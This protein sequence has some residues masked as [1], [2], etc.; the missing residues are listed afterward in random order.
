MRVRTFSW[1]MPRRGSLLVI[2]TSSAT[3]C[4]PSPTTLG[5]HPLGDG[6]DLV[7][8]DE[9]AVVVAG[10]EGLDDDARRE[11]LSAQRA[12]E[13]GADGL[14]G[15]EVELDA[16]AVVA[17]ERL[18][19]ARVAE[20]LRGGDR[21]RP[22]SSTTSARGTGSPASSSRRLVRLLSRRRRRRCRTSA[23][24][25]RPDPLLVGAVA[26][27]D[28]RVAVEADE[29]DVAAAASSMSAWVEGP[30]A[31]R[32]ASRMSRSSSGHEVEE[33][34]GSSGAT[35]W[36]TSATAILPG[37]EPDALLAVL[38]DD[39]VLAALAGAAGL[40]VADVGAGQVLELQ[41]DVLGDVAHPGPFAQAGDEAAATAERAGVVLEGRQQGDQGVVEAREGVGRESSR[42][43]RS[44]SRRMTGSRAQ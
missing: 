33:R 4:S 2:S 12:G 13:G 22:R 16:A 30:K 38:V 31:S 40:A 1:P 3:V 21:R 32:S 42:M 34:A 8:D 35:R 5:R 14:L 41:R 11:R 18:D 27:L 25:G 20:P 26:E 7:V 9:D 43:P 6:D 39:V 28:E 29:R 37:L 36:L 23:S 15:A 44:T 10:D 17:V 24:H 19:D